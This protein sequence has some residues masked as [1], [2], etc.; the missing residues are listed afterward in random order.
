MRV[1][2]EELVRRAD[3][4]LADQP[5]APG[6]PP[7]VPKGAP[8]RGTMDPTASAKLDRAIRGFRDRQAGLV[9]DATAVLERRPGKMT[10]AE[11]TASV[12]RGLWIAWARYMAAPDAKAAFQTAT[13]FGIFFD[14]WRLTQGLPTAITEARRYERWEL[15]AKIHA[16]LETRG[17]GETTEPPALGGNPQAAARRD[18]PDE[19]A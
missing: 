2:A 16:E 4:A 13:A 8:R 6:A 18:E 1:S 5:L 15:L 19:P 12:H 14:K 3:R 17:A 11:V 7:R 9:A 10:E